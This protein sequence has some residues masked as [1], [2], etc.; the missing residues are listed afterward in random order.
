MTSHHI[1]QT[2]ASPPTRKTFPEGS[3]ERLEEHLEIGLT[4]TGRIINFQDCPVAVM[5][6][7]MPACG[8]S[9]LGA[10][11][12]GRRPSSSAHPHDFILQKK[13]QDARRVFL[14][15]SQVDLVLNLITRTNNRQ[16]GVWDSESPTCLEGFFFFM[17]SFH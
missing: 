9:V 1:K 10:A 3:P 8:N 16:F 2:L 7:D 14:L 15:A 5:D 13:V 11:P 17:T 12:S 6:M 4:I